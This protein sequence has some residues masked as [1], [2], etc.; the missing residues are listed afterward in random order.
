M[1]FVEDANHFLFIDDQRGGRRNGGRGSHAEGLTSETG[2][3]EKIAG[4][5]DGY[6]CFFAD[7]IDDRKLHPA[8]LDIH[9]VLSGITLGE[10]RL[11]ASEFGDFSAQTGGVQEC[12]HIE[13]AASGL[14]SFWR[15]GDLNRYSS[16]GRRYHRQE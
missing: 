14:R 1:L 10:D 5:K 8:F 13:D 3:A 15:A 11:F 16:T 6:D 2:F 7:L 12:L 9:Y 4:A